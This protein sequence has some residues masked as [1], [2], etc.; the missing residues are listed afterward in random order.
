M[1]NAVYLICIFMTV[2]DLIVFGRT[3][4]YHFSFD[5]SRLTFSEI[6]G[7]DAVFYGDLD[8]THETGAPQL[9][10]HAVYLA[11]PPGRTIA[12]IRVIQA[13]SIILPG[14][15]HIYPVQPPH[16]LSNKTPV[17]WKDPDASIYASK[18]AY[19]EKIVEIASSGSLSGQSVGT[20][21]LYPVQYFPAEGKI[22][23]YSKITLTV[24]YDNTRS[25]QTIRREGSIAGPIQEQLL[26]KLVFNQDQLRVSE[27]NAP[28][29]S[30]S[31]EGDEIPYVII[32]SEALVPYF[33]PL[34][35]WKTKKGLPADIVTV[36]SIESEYS[37]VDLQEK[38]R[39]FIRE[40]YQNRG[41]LW[42][43]LGG[44][45]PVVPH[46]V[47][48]AFDCEY[49]WF[50]DNYLPC[51][52]Y[53]SDLDGSWDANGNGIYG[54]AADQI[55]MYPDVF[56][57]RAPVGNITETYAFVQKVLTYE[58]DAP[59]L[60][61]TKILF[62]AE[63][64]WSEPYQDPGTG[65]DMIDQ[66]YVPAQFDPITKLYQ[67]NSNLS[68]ASAIAAINDGYNVINHSG[69]GWTEGISV[70]DGGIDINDMDALQNTD[71]YSILYSIGCWPA[72][73]DFNCAAEHFVTNPSGGGVAFIGNS[74]YG[75][76]S[77]GNPGYGY[78]EL[79]DQQFF[80]ALFT[81]QITRLG[82]ALAAAKSVYVPFANY[83]NVYRWCEYTVNLMGDPEMP[84]WTDAP[85]ALTVTHPAELPLGEAL[86]MV[87]VTDGILA[88]EGA[89]VCLMQAD[90]IYQSNLTNIQ[91]QV[92]LSFSTSQV[93][94]DIQVT[95]TALN[96]VP[97]ESVITLHTTEPHVTAVSFITSGSPD[98]HVLPG[99]T[100]QVDCS[101]EN[102]GSAQASDV[103]AVL[104]CTDPDITLTDD[105]ESIG[106]LQSGEVIDRTAAFT[107][108]TAA[109]LQNGQVIP[110]TLTL[111]SA[112]G[113]PWTDQKEI[114]ITTPVLIYHTHQMSDSEEG[115]GD[116]FAEPGE[117]VT[118]DLTIEN[119]GL[120]AG[121]D[122]TVALNSQSPQITL[123]QSSLN[124]GTLGSGET[125]SASFDLQ[126][127]P[128][129]M[130]PDFITIDLELET[131]DGYLNTDSF[132]ISVG[133][134]GLQDDMESGTGLWS[135]TG[136]PDLWQPVNH[137][138]RTQN[139]S[140][141][142]GH[143]E[144]RDYDHDMNNALVSDPFVI[145]SDSE[146]DF[147]CWFELPNYGV[148]GLYV[149]VNNGAGWDKIDFFG[150]GGALPVLPILN[151]WTHY[152]Y[153]LSQ[154]PAGST[155]KIRFRF[156][157]D[158][159]PLTE[160][161]YVDDVIVQN[162]NRGFEFSV[163]VLPPDILVRPDTLHF[164]EV[165][166][167]A[168]GEMP[169]TIGNLGSEP[170][171]V[172]QILTDH[173]AFAVS[174]S[175]FNIAPYSEQ[176][177]EVIYTPGSVGPVSASLS[178][179]SN[180]PVENIVQ[181]HLTGE[182]IPSAVIDANPDSL[183]SHLFIEET[184]TQTLLIDN[185][186]GQADLFFR[187]RT[188][189]LDY[190]SESG[191]GDFVLRARSPRT[192]SCIAADFTSGLIYGISE[193]G[194]CGDFYC[195]DPFMNSWSQK[196]TC[197]ITDTYAGGAVYL[198]GN[199]YTR[200]FQNHYR[201]GVYNIAYD[202][203]SS[204]EFGG[205]KSGSATIATDD[206]CLYMVLEFLEFVKYNPE[207]GDW[208]V[209]AQ[210]PVQFSNLSCGIAYY[211]GYIYA[212]SWGD[213]LCRYHIASNTWE[214]LGSLPGEIILGIA[215]DPLDDKLYCYGPRDGNNWY[216]YDLVQETWSI[217][218]MP[219][220][221]NYFWGG[222]AYIGH[223]GVSG[224]YFI[225]ADGYP[226]L[227]ARYVTPDPPA[228]LTLSP[229]AGSVNAGASQ[230]ITAL[231]DA[232]GQDPGL[233]RANIQIVSNDPVDPE[234]VIPATC[235]VHGSEVRVRLLLEGAY[236]AGTGALRLDLN[237]AG[238]VP[239][240]SPYSEAPAT[241]T[242]IPDSIV[243]WVLVELR[244]DPAGPAVETRSALLSEH[245]YLC[246]VTG[247]PGVLFDTADGDY[248]LVIHHRNH[249]PVMST[250]K[251]S[252]SH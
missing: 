154:Y 158:D 64:L 245:G 68:H 30:L 61:E 156:V 214:S 217:L 110:C 37:G 117:T 67:A 77:P 73:F 13:D 76:A 133:E 187:I 131:S 205:Y 138:C 25:L 20:F 191:A 250:G 246:D 242:A 219:I 16:I 157:S 52:L 119:S 34:A 168:S 39:N 31:G 100:V 50:E 197:P 45:T 101:F 8:V 10:V 95:V 108:E 15:Y 103:T 33:Q 93:S 47:A 180:D 49:G 244:S 195:Y 63:Y 123:N 251:V 26:K 127:A 23:F 104:S 75:W 177:I 238:H 42:V 194:I 142:C 174:E 72:A 140:W 178:I 91:G 193:L 71:R 152:Y 229:L 4:T 146:L 130:I 129:C 120:L 94:T 136:S 218:T 153:S 252:L 147:W 235:H 237:A 58:R 24:R 206:H 18:G 14:T 213:P 175:D 98:G 192:L 220:N 165:L 79:L 228:W 87:T 106:T 150:S 111:S 164:G 163:P 176:E 186:M 188:D 46:R 84:V 81:D 99:S 3:D 155:L 97:Y 92:S 53:Y 121:E 247:A 172:S 44:D 9:P 114:V 22:K 179:Y 223:P 96:A 105:S 240:E 159:Q 11:V 59:H 134:F 202:T 112:S 227:F 43:L 201:F 5:R 62:L 21:F 160:G 139:T 128:S 145:D 83:K 148:N 173:E 17:R 125:R 90:G 166:A 28:S 2:T 198:N 78:S 167:R 36:S 65:K 248:Y 212:C 29:R 161:V 181:V 126:V 243:D 113:G 27:Y 190:E 51:D 215:V 171:V 135:H 48:F 222:M 211:N 122:V 169:L 233:L 144:T 35:D 151:T 208:T 236:E 204:I 249:L 70:A 124:Y 137:R 102:F 162:R 38:I 40:S 6:S 239:A 221:T 69:H 109:G 143:P 66:R 189:C 41:T 107:F 207:T 88:V 226:N 1:K 60:H 56:V 225:G 54:E 55:D 7:Y 232:G 118:V 115:D 216:I 203:W 74:R 57:G 170:L 183:G 19:P 80:K 132:V 199:I 241:C 141:Y 149:E 209:L 182:G 230:T 12:D 196:S 224:V 231:F 210:T 116:D 234:I 85:Y 184:E 86:C 32:T 82:N 89:R 200:F 185:S